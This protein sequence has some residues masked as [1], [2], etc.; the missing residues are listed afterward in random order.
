MEKES[1]KKESDIKNRD[2]FRIMQG[3]NAVGE[4]C[5]GCQT[6][7]YLIVKD[8][9]NAESPDY[10][11][12]C[13]RG[14]K[15]SYA[16]SKNKRAL[17]PEVE[18]LQKAG[19][20]SDQYTE[21]DKNRIELCKEYSKKDDDGNPITKNNEFKIADRQQ[22]DIELKKLE[23]KYK[24]VISERNKQLEDYNKLLDKPINGVSFHKLS[25][26]DL[27]ENISSAQTEMI[28]ELIQD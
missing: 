10:T 18:D 14:A 9:L 24:D 2:L 22:F 25:S 17:M 15:F 13:L 26:A 5:L 4:I 23:V 1:E 3:I 11:C 19:E 27:P 28:H 16:M 21:Y 12:T 7:Q 20:M 8:L 6:R